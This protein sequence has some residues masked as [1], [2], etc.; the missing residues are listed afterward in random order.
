[1]RYNQLLV[2][3][4]RTLNMNSLLEVAS[5]ER[6]ESA[7]FHMAALGEAG[8][9]MESAQK[10]IEFQ[11]LKFP[12]PGEAV[13]ITREVWDFSHKDIAS[14]A[15]KFERKD[16]VYRNRY[17]LRRDGSRWIIHTIRTVDE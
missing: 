17:E 13:V 4:Y 1:M 3:G 2:E 16:F 15:L 5:R 6:A 7:Y 11:E 14:G 10:K 8:I 9:R 12:K